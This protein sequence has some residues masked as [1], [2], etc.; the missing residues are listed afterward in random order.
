MPT[1][2]IIQVSLSPGLSEVPGALEH[3]DLFEILHSLMPEVNKFE[4]YQ[5]RIIKIGLLIVWNY[6][7][8]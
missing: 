1:T 6:K 8:D 2:V 5:S 7:K 3:L 4:C